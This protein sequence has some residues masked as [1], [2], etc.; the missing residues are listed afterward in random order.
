MGLHRVLDRELVEIELARDRGELLLARFV[1]PE[2]R[3]CVT[4]HAG[5]VQFG[6]VVRLRHTT[7]IAI[8]GT[9]DDHAGTVSCPPTLP[10]PVVLELELTL[11]AWWRS[12]VRFGC[13]QPGDTI[14]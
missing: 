8:D 11:V 13:P 7:A 3:D 6:E 2:P 5:S 9:I 12:T 4:G 10:R 1:Q 14:R